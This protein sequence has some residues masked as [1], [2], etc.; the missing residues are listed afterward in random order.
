MKAFFCQVCGQ[1][2]F[3]NNTQ[4]L[5]CKSPLGYLPDY[6]AI[7]ALEPLGDGNYVALL[8][9]TG[10]A[11][12]RRCRNGVE[13]NACNW[14][15]P[16]ADATDYCLSCELNKTIPDL[17]DPANMSDWR[18]LEQ[19][20]RRLIYSLTRLGL[21]VISKTRDPEHGLAFDFLRESGSVLDENDA[22]VITGHKDGLI[23]LNVAEADDLERELRKFLFASQAEG[24]GGLDMS[25]ADFS[26]I[27]ELQEIQKLHD[28][29]HER[30]VSEIAEKDRIIESL[31]AELQAHEGKMQQLTSVARQAQDAIDR[32]R[33][34]TEAVKSNL[35]A[36]VDKLQARVKE[37]SAAETQGGG[38]KGFFSR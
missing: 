38:R 20:K 25:K 13:F 2:L 14:M 4:C 19:G 17:S 27:T 26:K 34:E 3:F 37:L 11:H 33:R 24:S 12:Y 35:E 22:R 8:D 9:S 21:P 28:D 5:S 1:I 23:T 30:H 36:K 31:Q 10:G 15:L 18:K 32:A 7:S 29:A 6:H 16:S